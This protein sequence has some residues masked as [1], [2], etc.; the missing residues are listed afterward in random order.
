MYLL[1]RRP[2]GPEHSSPGKETTH[3]RSICFAP[4]L[5]CTSAVKLEHLLRNLRNTEGPVFLNGRVA[6][7]KNGNVHV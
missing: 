7:S 5:T 6:Y 3:A 4:S 2:A 1:C